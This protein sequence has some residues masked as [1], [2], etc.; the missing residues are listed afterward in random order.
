MEIRPDP[1]RST[2]VVVSRTPLSR[3]LAQKGYPVDQ[4]R[5]PQETAATTGI[6]RSTPIGTAMFKAWRRTSNATLRCQGARD[7]TE[8]VA[9]GTDARV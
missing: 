2:S 6:D 3:L 8:P 4:T 7:I 5:V 9:R 1:A